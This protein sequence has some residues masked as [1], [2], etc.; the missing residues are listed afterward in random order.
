MWK[1]LLLLLIIKQV[2]WSAFVPIWQF[3]DEQAHFA[4]VQNIAETHKNVINPRA[5]TSREIYESE[6]FLDTVRDGFGNNKYTY[7]PEYNIEYTNTKIGIYEA[8]VRSFPAHYRTDLIINEAAGYPPLYYRLS[9]VFYRFV[10][11]YDFIT[12]L[13]TTRF[14]NIFVYL[15]IVYL[16]YAIGRLLFPKDTLL[17]LSLI[18]LVAFHPMFSFTSAGINSDN[19]FNL[20]F[21]AVILS[22]LIILKQGWNFRNLIFSLLIVFL[23]TRIKPQ[24]I[25]AA[26]VYIY[27]LMVSFLKLN[28]RLIT[29]LI[30]FGV[31]FIVAFAN[32]FN[33]IVSGNQI[34]SEIPALSQMPQLSFGDFAGHL[35][36]TIK[37]TYRE[38][39]PWYWGIYRWL[40]LTYPRWVHRTINRILLTA[41][42]GMVVYFIKLTKKKP[43][44]VNLQTGMF[45]IFTSVM[46]FLSLTVFDYLFA[47]SHGFPFGIQG[48][49]FFP[50]LVAHMALILIGLDTIVQNTKLRFVALKLIG[51]ATVTLHTYAQYYLFKSYYSLA[52]VSGFFLQASQ[53]KPYIFK[54]P[55]LEGL[56]IILGICLFFFI[57]SLV[58]LRQI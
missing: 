34:I 52:N 9:A 4:Q 44:T 23:S 37:H 58:R 15:G 35:I 29:P 54:T 38:L 20:V 14:F 19:L 7:H 53:Y 30:S 33:N 28:K 45:F 43:L 1:V 39:L 8:A 36:W 24:G 49:Y 21:T 3:P 41:L 56:V 32:M 2:V 46:Y 48:R 13:F 12:R 11:K 26:L 18:I 6:I 42:I 55:F 27:P 40:S 17:Q 22:N 16:V 51:L 50:V 31:I 47:R 5:T 10:Y 57:K 25:L